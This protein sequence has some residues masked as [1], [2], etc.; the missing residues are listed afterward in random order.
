M[1][2]LISFK[3]GVGGKGELE[4]RRSFKSN[5]FYTK[6]TLKLDKRGSAIEFAS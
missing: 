6:I 2:G 4:A 1:T 5:Q 3:G